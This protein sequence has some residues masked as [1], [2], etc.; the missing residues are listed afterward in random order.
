MK[1]FLIFFGLAMAMV[2]GQVL[3]LRPSARDKSLMALREAARQQG[4]HPRLVA[5]PDWLRVQ[6]EERLLACYTL[7]V[8][9]GGQGL[10]HWQAERQIDGHWSVRAGDG[11]VLTGLTLPPEAEAV[12]AIEV[13]ANSLSLY[14]TESLGVEALPAL[15]QLLTDIAD[16]LKP[17]Q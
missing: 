11:D 7:F 3:M 12:L 2:L 13:R 8:E 5:R 6:P 4:L 17:K 10:P 16:K 1:T 15:T 9:E 14:W